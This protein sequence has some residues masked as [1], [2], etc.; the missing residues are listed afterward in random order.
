MH[1]VSTPDPNPGCAPRRET[2]ASVRGTPITQCTVS[3]LD[4]WPTL[5]SVGML[6][7]ALLAAAWRTTVVERLLAASVE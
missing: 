7:S 6:A 1:L 5:T 3:G 2:A 4:V